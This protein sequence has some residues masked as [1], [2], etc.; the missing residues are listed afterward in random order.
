MFVRDAKLE[1]LGNFFKENLRKIRNINLPDQSEF[2]TDINNNGH[3]NYWRPLHL[4][5]C[6][7]HELQTIFY[8][9]Y[10]C[11]MRQKVSFFIKNIL[12]GLSLLTQ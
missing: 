12:F 8:I 5:S 3:Q 6:I 9:Y 1:E 4:A 11:L 7:Y 2:G 10:L